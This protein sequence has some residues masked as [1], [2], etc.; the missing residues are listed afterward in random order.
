MIGILIGFFVM[1]GVIWVTLHYTIS[2]CRPMVVDLSDPKYQA[3]KNYESYEEWKK[4]WA[5]STK[6]F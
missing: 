4:D 3:M 1:C 5:Q 2:P 6:I